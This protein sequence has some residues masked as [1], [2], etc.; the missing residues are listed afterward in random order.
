MDTTEL[1]Q[2]LDHRIDMTMDTFDGQIKSVVAQFDYRL[3]GYFQKCKFIG[4]GNKYE[5]VI[6]ML[7][8]IEDF[9]SNTETEIYGHAGILFTVN[10][11]KQESD[12][13]RELLTKFIGT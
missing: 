3:K 4:P 10:K 1:K 2:K 7:E 5:T 12:Q 9:V 8:Q 11:N 13:A 6:A